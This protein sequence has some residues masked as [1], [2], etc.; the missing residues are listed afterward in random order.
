[1]R[2]SKVVFFGSIGTAI[3]GVWAIVQGS[4]EMSNVGNSK[5][6]DKQVLDDAINKW[7][8][9]NNAYQS[10][11][12]NLTLAQQTIVDAGCYKD[13]Y[14]SFYNNV[15]KY[16]APPSQ[17]QFPLNALQQAYGLNMQTVADTS[18][19]SQRT[20]SYVTCIVLYRTSCS[21]SN[22]VRTCTQTPYTVCTTNYYQIYRTTYSHYGSM[23][24]GTGSQVYMN[25]GVFAQGISALAA[26]FIKSSAE[27]V[28]IDRGHEKKDDYYSSAA[29]VALTIDNVVA[30][31]GYELNPSNKNFQAAASSVLALVASQC[32]TFIAGIKQPIHYQTIA[33]YTATEIPAMQDAVSLS[34]AALDQA[35]AHRNSKQTLADNSDGSYYQALSTWL[36]VIFVP[37]TI[38]IVFLCWLEKRYKENNYENVGT[39]DS[40]KSITC[41]FDRHKRGP[42]KSKNSAAEEEEQLP[43]NHENP[44]KVPGN[45]LSM[46]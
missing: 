9:A 33:N 5:D 35:T 18:Q 45:S 12:A 46:V 13:Q 31:T 7:N 30:T 16:C 37:T 44:D 28:T 42:V 36:P 24:S 20:A 41:C 21:T 40:E 25:C 1:M 19:A 6:Y 38:S 10:S 43:Y 4:I 15:T 39:F 27:V 3:Y 14:T 17:T 22:H 32:Q 8:L 34:Q 2:I 23:I 29:N 11:E 26:E